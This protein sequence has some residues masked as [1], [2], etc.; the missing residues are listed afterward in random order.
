MTF[1]FFTH[2]NFQLWKC[3]SL[4]GEGWMHMNILIYIYI[5]I[6]WILIWVLL[7]YEP[8]VLDFCSHKKNVL[9]KYTVFQGLP[10]CTLWHAYFGR[11]CHFLFWKIKTPQH[12]AYIANKINFL[13]LIWMLEILYLWINESKVFLHL[14]VQQNSKM[15][16][17]K[18]YQ[19]MRHPLV[20]AKDLYPPAHGYT[21]IPCILIL[22]SHLLTS[23]IHW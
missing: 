7:P 14:A 20:I 18:S 11:L 2:E 21:R 6:S 4:Y 1:P 5:Y 22:N 9:S 3:P 10:P 17:M 16:S 15:Y 23:N 13:E 8:I 19:L 12:S